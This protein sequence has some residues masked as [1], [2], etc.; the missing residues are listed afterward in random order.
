MSGAAPGHVQ[1]AARR[2]PGLVRNIELRGGKCVQ[3]FILGE[4]SQLVLLDQMVDAVRITNQVLEGE[5]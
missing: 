2:P 3:H 5:A 1:A 4:Q